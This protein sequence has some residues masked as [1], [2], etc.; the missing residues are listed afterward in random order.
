MAGDH[1]IPVA[2]G[3]GRRPR[4]F[5]DVA[6]AF[7]QRGVRNAFE[8]GHVEAKPGDL[9]AAYGLSFLES[10]RGRQGG[11]FGPRRLGEQDRAGRDQ[12]GPQ[13]PSPPHRPKRGVNLDAGVRPPSK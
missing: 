10:H 8:D 7:A 4:R 12:P 5:R 13:V 3:S 11:R 1:A 6:G 9:Q 2:A